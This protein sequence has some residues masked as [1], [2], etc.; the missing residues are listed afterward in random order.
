LI[1]YDSPYILKKKY[2]N[3]L[4]KI[5]LINEKDTKYI[6]EKYEVNSN[7]ILIKVKNSMEGLELINK[8]KKYIEN[9]EILNGNMDDVFLNVT[10]SR[11]KTG[12][13]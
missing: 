1:A 3:D 7:I 8:Y 9:F 4:V 2:A 10:G 5:K 6:K 12:V 13:L 11:I